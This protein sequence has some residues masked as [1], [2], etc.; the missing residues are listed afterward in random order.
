MTDSGSSSGIPLKY[1]H[2]WREKNPFPPALSPLRSKEFIPRSAPAH[3][4][5]V[6]LVGIVLNYTKYLS[7]SQSLTRRMD[8]HDW[9]RF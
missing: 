6:L 8:C 1:E 3:S 2:V 5:H 4:P 7:I 9:L